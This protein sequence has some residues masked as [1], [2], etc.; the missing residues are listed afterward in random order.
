MR[1]F[2][3]WLA[4]A[5]SVLAIAMVPL[6]FLT[7]RML[8]RE[9]YASFMRLRTRGKIR[10]FRMLMADPRIPVI[11]KV[12]P[13]ITALYLAMPFD[14]IPDFIPVLGY[15]DD[16]GIVLLALALMRRLS[17]NAVLTELMATA[18]ADPKNR[19]S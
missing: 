18:A 16:V 2:W 19:R 9:P 6:Y 11:V 7:K 15:M 13:V 1:G 17:P 5:L 10:F 12:I 14:I 3:L 8:G 4:I